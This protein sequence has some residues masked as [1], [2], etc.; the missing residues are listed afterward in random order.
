MIRLRPPQIWYGSAH[1]TPLSRSLG[2]LKNG[3]SQMDESL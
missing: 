3:P 2:S 1:T